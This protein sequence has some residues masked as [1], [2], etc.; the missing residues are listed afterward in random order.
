MIS[1]DHDLSN[2]AALHGPDKFAENNF[3]FAPVLFVENAENPKKNERQDQ[4]KRN[5]F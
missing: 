3:W 4:P 5:M 1:L 2:V